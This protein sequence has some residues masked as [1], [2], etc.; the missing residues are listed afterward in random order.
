MFLP[1]LP[2][3]ISQKA[4]KNRLYKEQ[5]LNSEKSK[6]AEKNEFTN[7]NS[8]NN[9]ENNQKTISSQ[10]DKAY[11]G[12]DNKISDNKVY[13]DMKKENEINEEEYKI[14]DSER[15]NLYIPNNSDD[16]EYSDE[17]VNGKYAEILNDSNP[18]KHKI[19]VIVNCSQSGKHQEE[20][21][22]IGVLK[23]SLPMINSYVLE[24]YEE[25]INQ[26]IGVE[27]VVK[28]EQD[29]HLTAQMNIAV[30]T[31]NGNWENEV[32]ALGEGVTVAILDTGLYPHNDFV[33]NS[34]RIINFKDF[35]NNI[36]Q[37]YDDNGHGTHVA[38]IIAGDGYESNGKYVGIAPKCN[39]IGI[40]VLGKDGSGNI[41]DVLAGVQW[42]LDNKE[43]YNIKVMNLSVG[44]EDNDGE[45]SALVKGVEAAWNQNIV[46]VCAAGNNGPEKGSVTTPGISRK[47]ITVG[48]SDDAESVTIQGDSIS[49]YS[50]RGPTKS[51][52]KKPDVVAPGSNI[53]SCNSELDYKPGANKY[54]KDR[55]G[56]I[57]KSGTSMATPMVSGMIARLISDY[58]NLSNKEIKLTMK[59][60]TNDLGYSQELQGWGLIDLKKIYNRIKEQSET[61]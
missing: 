58:P 9:L 22:K 17:N 34:N 49:N 19:Q 36:E 37:P 29:T 12:L 48:A 61:I 1:L 56:Y 6:S 33:Q 51:C 57:K 20:L 23:Y 55:I 39:L 26:L 10:K 11:N 25:N 8:N 3:L 41:S 31:V 46:V 16:K 30:E 40:K 38:G 27:G 47:V 59:Y 21:E 50:G 28:V 54:L 52:I 18:N 24:I 5:F 4:Q 60:S 53:I 13:Q 7:S 35:I 2:L 32:S 15:Y 14:I 43:K 42:V 45:N 44:M